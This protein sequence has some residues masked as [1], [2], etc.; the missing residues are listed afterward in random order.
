MASNHSDVLIG[1]N[2][3][4]LTPVACNME[5]MLISRTATTS[6]PAN[7]APMRRMIR[8]GCFASLTLLLP[9]RLHLDHTNLARECRAVANKPR[10]ARDDG[11]RD[12]KQSRE[13][14]RTWVFQ[15]AP[16]P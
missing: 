4:G 11:S 7:T 12:S 8:R 9:F 16:G 14:R 6:R 15:T 2:H 13:T 3:G 10:T 1:R 5:S